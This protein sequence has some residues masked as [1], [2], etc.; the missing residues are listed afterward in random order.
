[1]IVKVQVSLS[2]SDGV[3]RCLVYNKDRSVTFEDNLSEDVAEV[4]DGRPKGYFRATIGPTGLLEIGDE[5]E[6]QSW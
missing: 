4:M 6:E 2:T 5:V 3:A 1:M